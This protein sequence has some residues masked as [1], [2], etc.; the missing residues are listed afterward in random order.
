MRVCF[1]FLFT[2]TG[3]HKGYPFSTPLGKGKD[4]AAKPQQNFEKI[5]HVLSLQNRKCQPFSCWHVHTCLSTHTGTMHN[6]APTHSFLFP[7]FLHVFFLGFVL[8]HYYYIFFSELVNAKPSVSW[9]GS[10]DERYLKAATVHPSW[11]L[12][13]YCP[14]VINCLPEMWLLS[15]FF[16]SLLRDC[17]AKFPRYWEKDFRL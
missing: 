12:E 4:R 3:N 2:G 16:S 11:F 14:V 6:L 5:V 10:F 7:W 1:S 8:Q 15:L 13:E 9:K 17:K